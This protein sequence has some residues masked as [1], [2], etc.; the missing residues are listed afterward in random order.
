MNHAFIV[1]AFLGSMVVVGLYVAAL[2]IDRGQ[3][4]FSAR[5]IGAI[6]GVCAILI[7]LILIG[8]IM[9]WRAKETRQQ[10]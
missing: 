4:W 3:G 1:V 9:R 2:A 6:V 10:H 8:Q 5:L 7:P